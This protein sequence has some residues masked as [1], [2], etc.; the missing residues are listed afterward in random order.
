M[1]PQLAESLRSLSPAIEIT[2]LVTFEVSYSFIKK[3]FYQRELC[4]LNNW[5]VQEIKTEPVDSD[6]DDSNDEGPLGSNQNYAMDKVRLVENNHLTD[7]TCL[8]FCRDTTTVKVLYLPA[9]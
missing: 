4:L 2:P 7:F 8:G 3:N 5:F 6:A 9:T 1:A